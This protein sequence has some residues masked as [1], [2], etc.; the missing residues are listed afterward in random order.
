MKTARYV[1]RIAV[2]VSLLILLGA[3]TIPA[4]AGG[5]PLPHMPW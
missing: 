1:V 2:V 5:L 3:S 4:F